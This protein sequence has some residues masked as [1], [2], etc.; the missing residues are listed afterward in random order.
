MIININYQNKNSFRIKSVKKRKL[1]FSSE[2]ALT[3]ISS[4]TAKS[5]SNR[6]DLSRNKKKFNLNENIVKVNGKE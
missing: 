1:L 4:R 3:N 6:T 2:T 5:L